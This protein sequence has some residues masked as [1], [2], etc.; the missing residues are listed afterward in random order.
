MVKSQNL[1]VE[2]PKWGHEEFDM[3]ETT[4]QQQQ[5][6]YLGDHLTQPIHRWNPQIIYATSS[7]L[8]FTGGL[9]TKGNIPH[10][11]VTHSTLGSF[12]RPQA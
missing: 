4:Q 11:E 8:P 5:Q 10:P 7:H 1:S 12:S 6:R 3:T 2:D 9:A